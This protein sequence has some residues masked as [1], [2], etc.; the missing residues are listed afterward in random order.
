MFPTSDSA[1]LVQL[2]FITVYTLRVDCVHDFAGSKYIILLEN[3][4]GRDA[5]L[6]LLAVFQNLRKTLEP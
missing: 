3:L 5:N 1:K 6:V 2:H 4:F